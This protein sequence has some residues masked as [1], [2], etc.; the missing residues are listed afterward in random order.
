MYSRLQGRG[1]VEVELP[2]RRH[3]TSNARDLFWCEFHGR[4]SRALANQRVN[5]VK[6]PALFLSSPLNAVVVQ[7]ASSLRC[8]DNY[9][10]DNLNN[11]VFSIDAGITARILLAL[12]YEG[13]MCPFFLLSRV[14]L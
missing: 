9:W 2:D 6:I 10:H 14:E 3:T 7:A 1:V 12:V 5:M 4:N 8:T 13:A 11:T